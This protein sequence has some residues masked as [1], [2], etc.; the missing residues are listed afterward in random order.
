MSLLSRVAGLIVVTFTLGLSEA[1]GFTIPPSNLP[2]GVTPLSHQIYR[3]HMATFYLCVAIGVVVFGVL[4][5]SLFKYRRS[6]GAIAAHFHEHIGIE[7]LWTAIPFV[8][9]VIMAIP[10]TKI[11]MNIHNTA[12]PALNIKVIGYQWKWKYEYLEQGISFYSNLS[13]PNNQIYGNEK[14]NEFFLL[15][16]DNPVVVPIN[17]K[18]RILVTANDVIH[19]WWVPE[20]GIKQ[21]AIPGYINENWFTIEKAGVYRGQCAE[22]CGANHAFMPIVVKAVSQKEFD[23]WVQRQRRLE[24]QS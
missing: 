2:Y 1:L 14:K 4:I 20:L 3:L 17:A 18:I 22:L 15:E 7:I 5:Y 16:V 10:A 13:T 12:K 11:L 23:E 24:G 19:S 8:I 6:K 9:L 21:D